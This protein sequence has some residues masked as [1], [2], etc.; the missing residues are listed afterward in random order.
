MCLSFHVCCIVIG[1]FDK[2]EMR[3]KTHKFLHFFG[4]MN[5]NINIAIILSK[6]TSTSRSILF[7]FCEHK[8]SKPILKSCREIDQRFEECL[9]DKLIKNLEIFSMTKKFQN[10]LSIIRHVNNYADKAFIHLRLVRLQAFVY[11]ILCV[12][13]YVIL[14]F[15]Q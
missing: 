10:D 14:I 9:Q 6:Y 11:N 12:I 2:V 13:L 7:Y 4:K 5:K 8:L 15:I 3:T 1:C